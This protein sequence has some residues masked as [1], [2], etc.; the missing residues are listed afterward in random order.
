MFRRSVLIDAPGEEICSRSCEH[1]RTSNPSELPKLLESGGVF[2]VERNTSRFTDTS[3][4][5]AQ[6]TAVG[7]PGSTIRPGKDGYA[8]RGISTL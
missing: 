2:G 6:K 5:F 7:D 1:R 8:F 4:A 3:A